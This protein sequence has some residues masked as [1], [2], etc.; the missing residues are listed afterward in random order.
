MHRALVCTRVRWPLPLPFGGSCPPS[1]SPSFPMVVVRDI[2]AHMR[3]RL[4]NV[5]RSSSRAQLMHSKV[6]GLEPTEASRPACELACTCVP[7]NRPTLQQAHTDTHRHA[8]STCAASIN[9]VQGP[10]SSFCMCIVC[11]RPS[12]P[13]ACSLEA[14]TRC[15]LSTLRCSDLEGVRS[16][17]LPS[18]LN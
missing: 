11:M 17:P 12:A 10:P 15:V 5:A 18:P 3:I 9:P 16:T 6:H 1:R 14:H 8:A 2:Y 7:A 13:R 4:R